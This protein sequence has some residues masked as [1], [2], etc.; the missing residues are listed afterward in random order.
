M[1]CFSYNI[2]DFENSEKYMRAA[3]DFKFRVGTFTK[4]QNA[5]GSVSMELGEQNRNALAGRNPRK[6]NVMF[7]DRNIGH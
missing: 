2:L 5:D 6:N 4:R 1:S 7:L 3:C